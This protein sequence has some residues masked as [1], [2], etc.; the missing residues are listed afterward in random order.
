VL[1]TCMWLHARGATAGSSIPSG[2]GQV[3]AGDCCF[4]CYGA[5]ASTPASVT[6]AVAVSV[7]VQMVVQQMVVQHQGPERE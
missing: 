3:A 1:L 7:C 4:S 2:Y 5:H 6:A